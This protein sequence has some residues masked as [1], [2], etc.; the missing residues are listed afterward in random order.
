MSLLEVLFLP[1]LPIIV[2]CYWFV[3][4]YICHINAS[5]LYV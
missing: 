1:V 5:D 3:L 2:V 4:V